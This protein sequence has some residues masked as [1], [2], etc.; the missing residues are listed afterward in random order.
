MNGLKKNGEVLGHVPIAVDDECVE[1]R[2]GRWMGR[3]DR[4]AVFKVKLLNV[5][6]G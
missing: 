1:G 2:E 5:G 6:E 3:Y 4:P